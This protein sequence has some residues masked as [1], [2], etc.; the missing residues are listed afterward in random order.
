MVLERINAILNENQI[1]FIRFGICR[2][3]FGGKM[4]FWWESSTKHSASIICST[5]DYLIIFMRDSKKSKHDGMEM[6][7]WLIM[8]CRCVNANKAGN[9]KAQK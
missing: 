4:W 2:L 9:H 3:I 7:M 8:Q 1:D 5:K 6:K